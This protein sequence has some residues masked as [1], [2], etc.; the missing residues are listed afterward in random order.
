MNKMVDLAVIP[1]AGLGTRLW[2]LTKS[3][4]KEMLPLGRK[5]V[6]EHIV[7][8]LLLSGIRRFLFITGPGKAVIESHFEC[9]GKASQEYH[10]TRQHQPLGLGH[11]VLCAAP[12][13]GDR[14]FALAL[15]DMIIGLHAQSRVMERMIETFEKS[16]ADAVI[17]FGEVPRCD[18][19][20]YGIAQPRG[21]LRPIFE[22]A[23]V[24]EKPRV[25]EA[26]SRLAIAGRYVFGPDIFQLLGETPPHKSG[27]ILLTDAIRTLISKGG[28]VVG[29]QLAP[30]EQFFDIGNFKSYFQAF[31]QFALADQDYGPGLRKFV[32]GLVKTPH[33]FEQ[34]L[35]VDVSGAKAAV[36]REQQI[37]KAERR[38][39]RNSRIHPALPGDPKVPSSFRVSAPSRGHKLAR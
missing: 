2:P 29:M 25:K 13:V 8:E 12:I 11:A 33:C 31:C 23:D 17:V 10:F 20:H 1:A 4:P 5:P 27:E 19:V 22:L 36:F 7:E 18:V 6:V 34:I 9:N 30:G 16:S 3:Q 21:K 26:R 24:V 32:R 28:K 39:R 37:A 35:S 38:S 15:G 14:P